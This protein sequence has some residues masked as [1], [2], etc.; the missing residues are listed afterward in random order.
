MY[1][2]RGGGDESILGGI[3]VWLQVE[4]VLVMVKE[5]VFKLGLF[6]IWDCVKFRSW[7]LVGIGG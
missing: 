6:G 5:E 2:L 3:Y 4:K 7:L 1:I